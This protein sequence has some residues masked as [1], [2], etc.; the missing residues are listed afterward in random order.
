M[1]KD[2][3]QFGHVNYVDFKQGWEDG[4]QTNPYVNRGERAEGALI[5]YDYGFSEAIDMQENEYA[6]DF[7]SDF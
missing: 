2:F 5:A 3:E 7:G 4:I 1:T 6:N